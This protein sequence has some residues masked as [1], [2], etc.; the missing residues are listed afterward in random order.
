MGTMAV[1]GTEGDTKITWN[2][3]KTEEV[4]AARAHFD[5]MIKEGYKAYRVD[6]HGDKDGVM[7]SFDK[8]AEKVIF[9]PRMGGG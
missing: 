4:D 2:S 8:N 7:S 9:V 1:M 6:K 5:R 3:D